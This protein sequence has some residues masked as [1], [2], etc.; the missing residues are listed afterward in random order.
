ML[1]DHKSN[2]KQKNT[3]KV[4]TSLLLL[5][6]LCLSSAQTYTLALVSSNAVSGTISDQNLSVLASL[7]QTGSDDDSST[8]VEVSP[9]GSENFIVD[10]LLEL[11]ASSVGENE[12][13]TE[14]R[15]SANTIGAAKSVQNR[16]FRIRNYAVDS[17]FTFGDNT[18]ASNWVWFEQSITLTGSYLSKL[19]GP[20]NTILIRYRSD[21]AADVSNVDYLAVEVTTD[22]ER[23]VPS[24]A[25]SPS[26][27]TAPSSPPSPPPSP[28]SS[29]PSGASDSRTYDL[30]LVSSNAV[31]G[32]ISDQHLSV[33]ASLDQTGSD[34]ASSTYVEVSPNGSENFIV[35]FLFEL[36]A[37]GEKETITEIRIFANTIGTPKSV[38][39]RH[40]RI[41]NYAVDSWFTF[42]DNT[43]ASNWVWFEQSITLTGSYLSK[44]VGPDNTILIRYRSDNAADVSNVDYLAVEVTT[45]TA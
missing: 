45:E 24:T 23:E 43:G 16:H 12:T 21:N 33:L 44:L 29:P 14:I 8:F 2:W 31:S 15:I 1:R 28:P 27:S 6:S 5:A 42:G 37:A 18:G 41:R 35:D 38:Q 13:I 36:P 26:P 19:V 20:D 32:T 7:D 34:D 25:P 10:F 3:M 39:N 11:P 17:W 22:A 4:I 30:S 9:N 40:F